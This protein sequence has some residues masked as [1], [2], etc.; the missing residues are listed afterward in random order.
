MLKM[1]QYFNNKITSPR[2]MK[3]RITYF[4]DFLVEQHD[5]TPIWQPKT[6]QSIIE[7]ESQKEEIV[8]YL[9]HVISDTRDDDD[10]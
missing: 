4:K 1:A 9:D 6:R 5:S 3:Q 7:T 10:D 2:E 8:R